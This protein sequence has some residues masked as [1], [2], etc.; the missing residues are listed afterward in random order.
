MAYCT[1]STFLFCMHF[2]MHFCS[3]LQMYVKLFLSVPL[4]SLA[5]KLNLI[6]TQNHV[7]TWSTHVRTCYT[8]YTLGGGYK[9]INDKYKFPFSVPKKHTVLQWPNTN[10]ICIFTDK[11]FVIMKTLWEKCLD[12]WINATCKY[13]DMLLR[14]RVGLR[15]E[16]HCKKKKRRIMILQCYVL[17]RTIRC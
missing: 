6:Q 8:P 4:H 17:G 7:I 3:C 1:F 5:F 9:L 2:Y 11:Q 10:N 13:I 14:H 12:C 16:W 15:G